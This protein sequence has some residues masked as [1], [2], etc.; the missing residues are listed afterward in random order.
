MAQLQPKDSQKIFYSKTLRDSAN[1]IVI[2][3]VTYHEAEYRLDVYYG[4]NRSLD[5][6]FSDPLEV[7]FAARDIVDSYK[8]A[9]FSESVN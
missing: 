2:V 3:C 7:V 6:I 4:T 1:R 9:G 8:T 5:I